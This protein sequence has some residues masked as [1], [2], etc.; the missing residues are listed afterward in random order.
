MNHRPRVKLVA[1]AKDEA[2]YIPE[3]IHHHI[4]FGFDE[5]EVYINRTTD[6]SAEVLE[7]ICRQYANVSWDYADW[8]DMCPG[9]ASNQ[10]QFIVYARALHEA[11][12]TQKFSHILFLD[13]DEFWCT[14]RFDC[15]IQD[16]IQG[17]PKDKA[18][19]FEWI[20]DLGN[21]PPFSELPSMLEGNL[22]PLGKTLLPIDIDVVELRHHVPLLRDKTQHITVDGECFLPRPNLVQALSEPLNYLKEAFVFHRAHR[23]EYEYISLIYRG[24][25]GNSFKYKTN[26]KGLPSNNKQ[27]CSVV[28]P[29]KAYEMYQVSFAIFK[30]KISFQSD[31]LASIKFVKERYQ[32][33]LDGIEQSIQTHYSEMK[34]IF[35]G[36]SNT[37]VL[38][39]FKRYRAEK[40]AQASDN[41]PL[42]RDFAIDAA[43]QD[44][45]EAIGLMRIAQKLR[46]QGKLICKKLEDWEKKRSILA[47]DS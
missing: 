32:Q 12:K 41:V 34:S 37:H 28:L 7:K 1:I 36:I 15:S 24:R 2:A 10:I 42:I 20:N 23:S 4:Y 8:I 47:K 5:I 3:W 45:E 29:E 16:Y 31:I 44:L 17:L 35:F 9:D 27:A 13:I 22:S 46:P 25:P 33:S 18:V 38:N 11:K 19:F 14:Q 30:Q 39:V 43:K 40:I 21:L 6:N 26:R